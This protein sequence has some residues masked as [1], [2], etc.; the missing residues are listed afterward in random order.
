M[1]RDASKRRRTVALL[2]VVAIL[3]CMIPAAVGTAAWSG[4][5]SPCDQLL[6]SAAEGTGCSTV[7][8]V[9]P[10][11]AGAAVTLPSGDTERFDSTREIVLA[12]GFG[13]VWLAVATLAILKPRTVPSTA[14]WALAI[15]VAT[16]MV[17]V[18]DPFA[19]IGIVVLGV[20]SGLLVTLGRKSFSALKPPFIGFLCAIAVALVT[21]PFAGAGW[22][23]WALVPLLASAVQR[24]T[25]AGSW[26]LESDSSRTA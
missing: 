1:L 18:G 23:S 22:L 5:R 16:G 6:W 20:A 9:I 26:R 7:T 2:Y 15:V 17:G 21:F 25:G 14:P 11:Q 4:L 8:E 12:I 19:E 3:V 10:P 24:W 13:C